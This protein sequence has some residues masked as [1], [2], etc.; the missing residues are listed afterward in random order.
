MSSASSRLSGTDLREFPKRDKLRR[1]VCRDRLKNNESL[2][3][4][5]VCTCIARQTPSQYV[6][7][8]C[9]CAARSRAHT[10]THTHTHTDTLSINPQF[11]PK[12]YGPRATYLLTHLLHAAES[13]WEAN[14]FSASQEI[15]AILWNS[16]IHYSIHE[17]PPP[18][19]ILSKH[20]YRYEK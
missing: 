12:V 14:R 18:V 1:H 2:V 17:F 5:K 6:H 4:V 9:E 8:L 15:A 19:P 20:N 16:K 13:F 10:H 3:E 7:D 11:L